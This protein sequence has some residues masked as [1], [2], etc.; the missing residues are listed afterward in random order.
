MAA[1]MGAFLM[2]CGQKGKRFSLPNSRIMIHQPSGGFQGTASDIEI[3]A[4]E[5]I[6]IRE[7]LNIILSEK[8]GQ[9]V[10]KITNDSDRD[11]WMD[12]NEAK[13]YGIVDKVVEKK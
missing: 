9:K 10:S 13:S 2:A 8:T 3:T 6:K 12:A 7:K 1:S 5:I 11:F 4:K